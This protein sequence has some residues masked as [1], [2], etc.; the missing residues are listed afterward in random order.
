MIETL[1]EF[2]HRWKK[3]NISDAALLVID[4]QEYFL[5]ENSHAY[6]PDSNHLIKNVSNTIAKFR[7]NSRPVIHTYF[8]VKDGEKD[9]IINWWNDSVKDGTFESNIIKELSP[10]NDEAVIRKPTYDS[11]YETGLDEILKSKNIKQVVI[12]GVVTNLCCETSARE[13]FVRGYDTFI[14]TDGMASYSQEMHD[15]SIRNLAY[16][17]ATPVLS[18]NI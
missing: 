6:I 5:N 11:F 12:V 15:A 2:K 13:S 4:M 18:R 16:G 8:A 17:F 3:L 10:E 14:V 1:T 7:E 9:S